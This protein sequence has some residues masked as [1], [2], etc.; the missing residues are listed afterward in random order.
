MIIGLDNYLGADHPFY[1]GIPLYISANMRPEQIVPDAASLL[2]KNYI[3]PARDRSFL[4]QMIYHGKLLYLESL[5]LPLESEHE[6][7]GYTEAQ[8]QWT[9]EN[10]QDIWRYF[11][12]REVLFNTDPKLMNRFISPAPFSKFY[13]EID[14]ESPGRIGRYMGW[15]MVKAYAENTGASLGEVLS[16]PAAELYQQ[17]KY[18]PSK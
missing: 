16:K 3:P 9:L 2:A 12:E 11:V 1:Q 18:K 7:M 17:S 15:Q 8:W 10:E 4:G 5:L 14:N 13:L 6:I